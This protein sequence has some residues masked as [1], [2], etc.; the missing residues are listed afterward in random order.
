MEY[1]A[2]TDTEYHEHFTYELRFEQIFFA[3]SVQ[4]LAILDTSNE[5]IGLHIEVYNGVTI[6]GVVCIN[7]LTTRDFITNQTKSQMF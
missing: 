6:R 5:F 3:N 4:N 2:W 7:P 1:I